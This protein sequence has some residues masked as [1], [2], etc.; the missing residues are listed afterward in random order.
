MPRGWIFVYMFFCIGAFGIQTHVYKSMYT[1]NMYTNTNVHNYVFVWTSTQLTP[2]KCFNQTEISRVWRER[3]THRSAAQQFRVR[4]W[5]MTLR[6]PDIHLEQCSETL[7]SENA[8]IWPN[9]LQKCRATW[10]QRE[11]SE[12]R[13]YFMFAAQKVLFLFLTLVQTCRKR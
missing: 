6:M 8:Q 2:K 12:L 9:G 13:H 7:K 5:A 11:A 4:W 1:N 10:S 3:P